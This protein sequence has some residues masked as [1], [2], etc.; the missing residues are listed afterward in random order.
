[1]SFILEIECA[2]LPSLRHEVGL[3]LKPCVLGIVALVTSGWT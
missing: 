1:M 2:F 3:V